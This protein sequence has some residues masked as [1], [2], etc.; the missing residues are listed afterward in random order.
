MPIRCTCKEDWGKREPTCS[1]FE[2]C[3]STERIDALQYALTESVKL[4]SHYAELL[5]QY[6]GG[7]RMTFADADAWCT[8]LLSVKSI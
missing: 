2:H 1:D 6:D 7:K 5:N 4:Q 3:E 8:R